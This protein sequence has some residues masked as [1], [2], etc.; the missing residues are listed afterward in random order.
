MAVLGAVLS[1]RVSEDVRSG[2]ARLGV[3]ADAHQSHSIPDLS[4]LPGPVRAVFE[5]AFGEAT[6]YLFLMAVPVAA[7][8]LVAVSFIREVPLRTR[9]EMEARD[10]PDG[11]ESVVVRGAES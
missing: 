5:G 2:L 6:G 1:A 8:A 10:T 9:L 11:P 4:A 3:E 7:L